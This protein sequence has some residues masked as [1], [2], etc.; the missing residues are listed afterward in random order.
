MSGTTYGSFKFAFITDDPTVSLNEAASIIG[1]VTGTVKAWMTEI[2]S[3]TV[4][5]Y[6][7]VL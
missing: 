5:V 6:F 3:H 1:H 7:S 4:V 2:P